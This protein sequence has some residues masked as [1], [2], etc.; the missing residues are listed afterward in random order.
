V[1]REGLFAFLEAPAF[2]L[3]ALTFFL[4]DTR[5]FLAM[6][7]GGARGRER[8]EGERSSV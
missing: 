6:G 5:V 7:R 2:F 4:E 1:R 3:E 8:R